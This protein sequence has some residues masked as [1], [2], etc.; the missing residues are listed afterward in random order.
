M[1]T[2]YVTYMRQIDGYIVKTLHNL[3]STY[4]EANPVEHVSWGIFLELK[5]FYVRTVTGRDIG[6]CCY[7]LHITTRWSVHTLTKA[8]KEQKIDEGFASL[9]APTEKEEKM[10]GIVGWVGSVDVA[11]RVL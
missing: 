7:K 4:L 6:M 1:E 8:C 10:L 3:Y 9:S 5:P 2:K 11:K